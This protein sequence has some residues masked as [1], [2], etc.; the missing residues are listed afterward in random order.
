MRT[1]LRPRL[2]PSVD[3]YSKL[4]A[5]RMND[6]R[7]SARFVIARND[8]DLS[9]TLGIRKNKGRTVSSGPQWKRLGPLAVWN[10]VR[11]VCEIRVSTALPDGS[12]DHRFPSG[13]NRSRPPGLTVSP[14]PRHTSYCSPRV[15]TKMR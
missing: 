2:R 10:V 14:S 11:L 15:I 5:E 13:F 4:L 7:I 8:R 9:A 12:R 1:G 3:R 6:G